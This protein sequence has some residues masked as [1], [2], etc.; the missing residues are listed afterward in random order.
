MPHYIHYLLKN[1]SKT[2]TKKKKKKTEV[3]QKRK[4][5]QKRK[6]STIIEVVRTLAV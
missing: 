4:Q 3:K 5:T 1:Y 2:V 6:F